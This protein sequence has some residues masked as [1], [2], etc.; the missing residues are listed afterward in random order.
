MGFRESPTKC[1]V[2]FKTKKYWLVCESVG[3]N[4][5]EYTRFPQKRNIF[6]DRILYDDGFCNYV[7]LGQN[8]NFESSLDFLWYVRVPRILGHR[9][10]RR[11]HKQRSK[12]NEIEGKNK[13]REEETFARRSTFA[14]G[15]AII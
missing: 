12:D 11:G 9:P 7:V 3:N 15:Y 4:K 14:M 5:R 1:G 2:S 13:V 6:Q 8:A 10:F